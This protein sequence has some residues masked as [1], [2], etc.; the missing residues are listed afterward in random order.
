M[1]R[2]STT[3]WPLLLTVWIV[4]LAGCPNDTTRGSGGPVDECESIGQQCRLGGGQLGVCTMDTEGQMTC[5][6]QH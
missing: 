2:L 5:D 4:V 6:P 3:C 1:R